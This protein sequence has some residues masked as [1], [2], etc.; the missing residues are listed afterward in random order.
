MLL[1]AKTNMSMHATYLLHPGVLPMI[2]ETCHIPY[3]GSINVHT[4]TSIA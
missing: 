3:S 2:K 1:H 4:E